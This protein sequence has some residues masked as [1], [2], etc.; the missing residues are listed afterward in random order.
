MVAAGADTV[1]IAESF[2]P[3]R[4]RL[5]AALR[6]KGFEIV[7]TVDAVDV[8][9][10]LSKGIP[11]GFV[12]SADLAGG[13]GLDLVG[14]LSNMAKTKDK[15]KVVIIDET[16]NGQAMTRLAGFDAV[17]T[18]GRSADMDVFA[19]D[20][21]AALESGLAAFRGM[22]PGTPEPAP[23]EDGRRGADSSPAIVS[24]DASDR[25][26]AA[27][28]FY[29]KVVRMVKE[30]R[31][32]GP[33]LPEI[34]SD[35]LTIFANP[36][37]SFETVV[38]LVK[39]HQALAVR[40][41][42]VANSAFYSCAGGRV[43]SITAA[44]SRVGINGARQFIQAAATKA[45]EMGK[46]PVLHALIAKRL[47][48]SYLVAMVCD[49]L[50]AGAGNTQT[51]VYAVGLLHNVGQ[52]FLLY[53]LALLQEQGPRQRYDAAALDVMLA[54][55]AASLNNLVCRALPLPADVGRVFSPQES[56]STVVA[57]V[58]QAIWVADRLGK[59]P[60]PADLVHDAEAELLGL[61]APAL[62]RLQK[63]LPQ[64]VELVHSDY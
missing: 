12:V 39:K 61:T 57:F 29:E 7:E 24:Q 59:D 1:L 25:M 44:M 14:C 22:P 15:P 23:T 64:I 38:N 51:D 32:P 55:R 54:N 41:L 35:A 10:E 43:T 37:V 6:A 18:V 4:V 3:V 26:S 17:V 40:L 21:V 9:R 34:L 16:D 48:T 53:T 8:A 28:T 62:E 13:K 31:L 50:A 42:A 20:V 33:I 46:D 47:E 2:A 30:N 19:R 52:T 60:A 36:N 45:F 58:H 49:R 11:S 27:F 5:A 63:H 56:W